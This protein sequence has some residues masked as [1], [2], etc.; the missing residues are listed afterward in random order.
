MSENQIYA[1]DFYVLFMTMGL[2][3]DYQP[4]NA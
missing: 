3:N 1:Q 4:G 2:G